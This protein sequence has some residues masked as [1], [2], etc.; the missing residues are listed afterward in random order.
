M[1]H[2]DVDILHSCAQPTVIALRNCEVQTMSEPKITLQD[3]VNSMEQ[4]GSFEA[5]GICSRCIGKVAGFVID[6]YPTAI[7][8]I[9]GVGGTFGLSCYTKESLEAKY[10]AQD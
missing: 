4:K 9:Y 3:I 7:I 5:V 10:V 1:G 6:T 2:I 8:N